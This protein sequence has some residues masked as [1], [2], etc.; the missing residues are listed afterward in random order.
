MGLSAC[1]SAGQ[2]SSRPPATRNGLRIEHIAH[3][4][5]A[6]RFSRRGRLLGVPVVV[7]SALVGTSIASQPPEKIHPHPA[8]WEHKPQNRAGRGRHNMSLPKILVQSKCIQAP[9]KIRPKITC[10]STGE[11]LKFIPT[12][13]TH[14][15]AKPWGG[16]V[17]SGT[18]IA[19]V[20]PPSHPFLDCRTFVRRS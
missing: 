4:R 16:V 14:Q 19:E 6:V 7:P 20:Y 1:R 18:S 9:L 5:A 3:S 15:R 10:H 17:A 8:A 13:L 12:V 11:Q 2:T